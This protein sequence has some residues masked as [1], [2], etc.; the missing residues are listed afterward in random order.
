[1]APVDGTVDILAMN[2]D[3]AYPEHKNNVRRYALTII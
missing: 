2:F 3:L 1:M